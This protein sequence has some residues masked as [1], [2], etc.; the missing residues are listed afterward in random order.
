MIYLKRPVRLTYR[1]E[2]YNPTVPHLIAEF[3]AEVRVVTVLAD[4]EA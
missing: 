1:I 4:L 2:V 3:R